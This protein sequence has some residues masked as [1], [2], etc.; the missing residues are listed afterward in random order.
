M[1]SRHTILA[2]DDEPEIL[3]LYRKLFATESPAELDILGAQNNAPSPSL[4][5]CLTYADPRKLLDDYSAEVKQGRRCPLCIVDMRM[6]APDEGLTTAIELRKIDEDID[7]IFCTAVSHIIPEEI[8]N[9][10]QKRVFFVGK[11][12]NNEEFTLMVQS[13]VDYW[14]SRQD[15]HNESAFANS[16]L[17]SATDLIFAKDTKGVYTRCNSVF[18]R[19]AKLPPEKVIGS[20][21]ICFLPE[22]LCKQFRQEDLQVIKTGHPLTTRQWVEHPD[23]SSCQL[24]TVKSPLLSSSGKCI[25]ILGVGRDVTE[26]DR[27]ASGYMI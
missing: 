1:N 27:G 15:L 2:I 10:L 26:R 22:N 16:L 18:A 14:Q 9:K 4:I 25:G 19:F 21:D 7:I 17:E 20:T 13:L 23:G 5:E 24:E 6:S 3:E 11:P 8:R 12:F